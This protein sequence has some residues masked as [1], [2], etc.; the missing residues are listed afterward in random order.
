MSASSRKA[1]VERRQRRVIHDRPGRRSCR[2]S[3]AARA[4][5]R[6]HRSNWPEPNSVA[7]IRQNRP[8]TAGLS[9]TG[10]HA[11]RVTFHLQNRLFPLQ[12]R[13]RFTRERPVPTARG[14]APARTSQPAAPGSAP[15]GARCQAGAPHR[16]PPHARSLLGDS[17]P[18]G[19]SGTGFCAPRRGCEKRHFEGR[20]VPHMFPAPAHRARACDPDLPA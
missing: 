4:A 20:D 7:T 1:A 10:V 18:A 6:K 12:G 16:P 5:P 14:A 19:C 3:S 2:G 15:P 9:S 17:W 8:Q 11:E 13:D